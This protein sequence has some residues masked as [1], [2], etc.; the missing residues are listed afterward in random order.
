MIRL[1]FLGLAVLFITLSALL[2]KKHTFLP[3]WLLIIKTIQILPKKTHYQ[4]FLKF[5]EML[6]KVKLF[7]KSG[8]IEL[9]LRG[10]D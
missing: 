6:P 4:I 3:K 5:H 1:Y 9:L 2:N 8:L 10:I 7:T